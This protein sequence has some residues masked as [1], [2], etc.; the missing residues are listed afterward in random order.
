MGS[1]IYFVGHVSVDRIENANGV[2]VQPGGAALYAAVAAKTL[3]N[4]V[5]L[6][7]AVG[8]DYEFM[9]FL[10][11]FLSM[12]VKFSGMPST[13]FHIKYNEK[14]EAHYLKAEYGAGSRIS[15]SRMPFETLKPDDAVH[16]SPIRPKKV[17]EIVEKIKNSSPDTKVSVNTW[18]GY[19]NES[20]RNRKTLKEVAE[21]TDFFILNDSE[22]KALTETTSLSTALRLLKAKTLVITLGELG[23]IISREGGEIQ[24]VPALHYPVKKVVDTTG[25]GDTWC[26][27]FIAA[28]K[29]TNDLMKSVTAASIIS[30]VKC[31][32]WGFNSIWNLRFK[33]VN[34]VIEYVIGLKEGSLQKRISDYGK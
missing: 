13:R 26:G 7:S 11:P 27:S 16:I 22:A 6:F 20:K 8:R 23:A 19:V 17:Y 15:V 5:R 30:S 3:F 34:D 32:G 31:T 2:R 12:H 9:N 10:E 21:K 1:N 29:L 28:Y 24:M 33:D 25:A 14:W 18:V 4:N